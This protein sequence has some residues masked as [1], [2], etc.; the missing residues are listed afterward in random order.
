MA[1]GWRSTGST[2]PATPTPTATTATA[3]APVVALARLG[4]RRLQRQH[5]VRPVHRR[6]AGRRPA[7]RA[8]PEQKIATGFN[9]NHM[10]TR[11]RHRST[12]STASSTS[13]TGWIR[14]ATVWLGLT[15]GCARCHDH[16]YDPITQK[17][18][19]E[20][21]AFFNNV[22][23]KGLVKA[24]NPPPVLACPP[25]AQAAAAEPPRPAPAACRG[26]AGGAGAGLES[27]WPTGKLG[28]TDV[29]AAA[30]RRAAG[31]L[32]LDGDAA[33]AGPP[34]ITGANTSAK[35]VSAPGVSGPAAAFDGTQYVEFEGPPGSSRHSRSRWP[36]WIKPDAVAERLRGFEDGPHGRRPRLRGHLVQVA[37]AD[38]PASHDG[39]AAPSKSWPRQRSRPVS[40]TTW[41]FPTTASGRP[42]G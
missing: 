31:H 11:G 35:R 41:W 15:L 16:K 8:T 39:A 19:Y 2:R 14:P 13:S 34:R 5:A 9:R 22:P 32:P 23:E 18:Y 28:M 4:H 17:E 38:Q 36:I 29:G 3:T 7:A 37:A 12:R 25:P 10:P 24:G 33:D 6:A 40:G 21:F 30:R 20:L 27:G 1:S 26:Q 42:R